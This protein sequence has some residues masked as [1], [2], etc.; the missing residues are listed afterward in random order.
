MMQ[1][2][3]RWPVFIHK[4][5]LHNVFHKAYWV[6]IGILGFDCARSEEILVCKISVKCHVLLRPVSLSL[7]DV[8]ILTVFKYTH[9]KAITMEFVY[10]QRP[11]KEDPSCSMDADNSLILQAW[12]C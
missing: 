1:P 4:P 11:F 5:I 10:A 6:D 12:I 9:V 7:D 2:H 3:Q 8:D